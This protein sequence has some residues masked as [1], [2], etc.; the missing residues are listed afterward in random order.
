VSTPGSAVP[1]A[2]LAD[3]MLAIEARIVLQGIFSKEETYLA[4]R[5]NPP[6]DWVGNRYCIILFTSNVRAESWLLGEGRAAAAWE[7]RVEVYVRGRQHGDAAYHDKLKL[8]DKDDGVMRNVT[9]VFNALDG[10]F[11][12]LGASPTGAALTIE[13]LQGVVNP[14]PRHRYQAPGKMENMIG[15]RVFYCMPTDPYLN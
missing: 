9:R 4:M 10:W 1:Q 2:E 14:E 13:G 15:F 3:I 6:V 12:T 11:P 8:T 5:M 7:A